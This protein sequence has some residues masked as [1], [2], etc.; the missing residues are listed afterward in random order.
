VSALS[1]W[2]VL[3]IAVTRDET[4][5]R[6]AYAQ[7]LRRTRPED[8]AAGFA[9]LR[10]AYEQ[11]LRLARSGRQPIPAATQ[12]AAP[13]R[14]DAAPGDSRPQD[15]TPGQPIDVPPKAGS[16]EDSPAPIRSA[17]TAADSSPDL[18]RS[19]LRLR[20]LAGSPAATEDELRGSLD[21]CLRS[22]GLTNLQVQLQFEA[23]LAQFLGQTQPRTEC[24]LEPTIERFG[25]RRRS[26]A[27]RSDSRHFRV[28][29][30]ADGALALQKAR[31]ESP[32]AHAAITTPPRSSRLWM[33]ILLARLDRAVMAL[34]LKL[35]EQLPLSVNQPALEW[36]RR[37]FGA[38]HIRPE[39]VWTAL[40][41]T[42]LGSL[43]GVATATAGHVGIAAAM[44]AVLGALSGAALTCGALWLIDWPRY[45][46]RTKRQLASPA[47]RLGWAPT[48]A[49]LCILSASMASN[50]LTIALFTLLTVVNVAW[51]MVM[52]RWRDRSVGSGSKVL[53]A[54]ILINL[55]VLLWC[56]VSS[57]PR[58]LIVSRVMWPTLLGAIVAF[59]LGQLS[60]L[61]ALL[62][63]LKRAQQQIGRVVVTAV[64]A[65]LLLLTWLQTPGGR[66]SSILFAAMITLILAARVFA[67]NLN[68][69]QLRMR[70]WIGLAVFWLSGLAGS[71]FDAAHPAPD[72]I[73]RWG[74][75]FFM[76][77]LVLTM[78][79]SL[80][81][82]SA[83]TR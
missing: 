7:K 37:Y 21:D 32:R 8:D 61:T 15:A 70:Y 69:V 13:S 49:I 25:W 74:G 76:V 35:G 55:P 63:E 23:A 26:G 71:A 42:L 10:S 58:A 79:V 54:Q 4:E 67:A 11:A 47:V 66:A 72:L 41:L 27:T 81:N 73:L 1:P 52:A 43:V 48:A 30:Y 6:R 34:L 68:E 17:D 46:L 31:T 18:Q 3:E 5:I 77:S 36:W 62:Q 40:A 83:A 16:L 45:K 24:L 33:W 75:S 9:L 39:M 53:Y 65:G 59:G 29:A 44:G 2:Q 60:L 19:F 50:G 64:A 20:R 28:V 57:G 80:H 22:P 56:V 78:I 82:V 12:A 14:P 51:A 38:P